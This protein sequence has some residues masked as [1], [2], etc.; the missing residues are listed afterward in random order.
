LI[1]TLA[2]PFSGDAVRPGGGGGDVDHAAA[3]ERTPVVDPNRD[4]AAGGHIGDLAAACRTAMCGARRSIPARVLR[5]L[6]IFASVFSLDAA[7]AISAPDDHASVPFEVIANLVAKS[8]VAT[9]FNATAINEF[10]SE[11]AR[12]G[13]LRSMEE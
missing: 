6:S 8:V 3:N 4:G 13:N 10:C 11:I 2:M 9:E 12:A 7:R 1:F 5:R